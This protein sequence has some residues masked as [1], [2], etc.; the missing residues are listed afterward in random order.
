MKTQLCVP[1]VSITL[2]AVAAA[3][4]AQ[5]QAPPPLPRLDGGR[6]VAPRVANPPTLDGRADDAAWRVAEPLKLSVRGVIPP[7]LGRSTPVTL[8]SI[9]TDSHLYFL[10]EVQDDDQNVSH[11][12][13]VWN[14]TKGAYEEGPDREDMMSLAFEHTGEFNPDMLSSM[15]AVWDLWHWKAFRTNPQGY[16]MD[17]THRYSKTKPEGK[18]ASYPSRD[19]S[20]IWIARPQDAG[21]TVE[22][23][24][25]APTAHQGD[26][27]AAYKP[28]TPTQSAADVQAKGVWREG[29]WTIELAR[30]LNT[31]YPDDTPFDPTRT[32]KMAVSVHDQ[33]GNMDQ[34]SGVI[35]L[36][37]GGSK[38]AAGVP[39][40]LDFEQPAAAEAPEGFTFARTGTGSA[41]KWVIREEAGAPSGCNVLA[42][43]SDDRT[44]FRFPL[45][46]Y[47]GWSGKDV[48]LSVH[49]KA[50]SGQVDQ[51]AGLVWR[52][53]NPDNYYIV[54]ANAL[55]E[56]VVLYKVQDGKRSDLPLVG[57]GKTY[58]KKAPV[59]KGEWSMLRLVARGDRF[60]VHLNGKKLYEVVDRT[61]PGPGKVGLWTKA[62]SVTLFDD[63]KIAAPE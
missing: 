50:I 45:A 49:F 59:P 9:H 24:V 13:W 30:R 40:V 32:Y 11:K 27:V 10:V 1:V 39:A 60:T 34:A 47:E 7:S 53:Q 31:G 21:D 51:A 33:T 56:N 6:L 63:L 61:F 20:T 29:R 18:A 62:D 5:G 46:V 58:G 35:L 3:S 16:A 38:G 41:G 28:G 23:S 26:R 19:G 25:P 55:E 8:R 14:A 2:L 54:R 48:D 42:Q 44:S 37:F 22:V 52:Y 12:S 57:E 17:K 15:D 36:S 43:V 4:F